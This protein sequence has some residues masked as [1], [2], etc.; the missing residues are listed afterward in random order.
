LLMVQGAPYKG[1]K[2]LEKGIEDGIVKEKLETLRLLAQAMALAQ[3][4][5][6][7]IP[8]LEKAAKLAKDGEIDLYLGQAWMQKTEWGKASEALGR[9][10]QKGVKRPGPAYL[11]LGTARFNHGKFDE[12]RS[13]FTRA[14]SDDSSAQSAEQWLR[15]VEAEKKRREYLAAAA[16]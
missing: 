4:T 10:V 3:E 14:R 6:A 11:L 16:E 13:A 8:V 12:A 7:Q 15:Y 9:A 1:W 5:D 2:V